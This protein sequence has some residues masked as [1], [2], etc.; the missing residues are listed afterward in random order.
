MDSTYTLAGSL[1]NVPAPMLLRGAL[2]RPPHRLP[3]LN[4]GSRPHRPRTQA[5]AAGTAVVAPPA[6][7]AERNQLPAATPEGLAAGASA[8]EQVA[9]HAERSVAAAVNTALHNQPGLNGLSACGTTGLTTVS[10]IHF[11][12]RHIAADMYCVTECMWRS[13]CQCNRVPGKGRY[14]VLA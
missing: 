8:P 12:H 11:H 5:A 2:R 10:L 4:A 9:D 6:V 7:H 1:Q 3:R 13:L 14:C